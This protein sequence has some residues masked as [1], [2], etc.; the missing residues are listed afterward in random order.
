VPEHCLIPRPDF[1]P[2]RD[3]DF[4]AWQKNFS[5]RLSSDSVAFGISPAD[6][7]ALAI[8]SDSFAAALSLAIEP[9]SRTRPNIATKNSA[10][11]EL[12]TRARQLARR[13]QSDPAVTDAQKIDLGLTPSSAA[14]PAGGPPRSR[15]ILSVRPLTGGRARLRLADAE[16]PNHRGKPP[17]TVG[18]ILF[19]KIGGAMPTLTQDYS[20]AG[21]A[22]TAIHTIQLPPEA[23]CQEIWITAR[24]FNLRG[25]EGPQ[26]Y[27]ARTIGV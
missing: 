11:A 19:V 12:A 14:P 7:A 6:A 1:I 16:S 9:G 26:A 21:M 17:G 15:P 4:L 10:R 24:W 5:T 18:A 25:E 8:L 3:T 13:I 2:R 27:P 22:T 23:H 20:Y